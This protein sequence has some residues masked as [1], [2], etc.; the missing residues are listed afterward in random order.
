MRTQSRREW[1]FNAVY[2]LGGLTLT[3]KMPGGGIF[4]T[5]ALAG[6]FADPLAP[7]QPHFPP[8]GQIGHLAAYGRGS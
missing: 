4:A 7:K 2:G 3:A 6:A 5:P 1:I 8:K